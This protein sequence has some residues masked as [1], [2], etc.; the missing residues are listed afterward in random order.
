MVHFLNCSRGESAFHA[1]MK[2]FGWAKYPMLHRISAL[3]SDV[4]ITFIYG[5]RSWIDRQPGQIIKEMRTNSHPVEIWVIQ[6]AGHHVYGKYCVLIYISRKNVYFIFNS[7]DKCDE[8]N[9][10]VLRACQSVERDEQN[11]GLNERSWTDPSIIGK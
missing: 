5:A 6:G 10:L 1:M 8:F 7:A 9:S 2:S 3:R 4:P 11:P